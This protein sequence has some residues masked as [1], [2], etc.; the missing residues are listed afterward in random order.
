M[1]KYFSSKQISIKASKKK[2]ETPV[3]KFN[4]C[5]F[6]SSN[7]ELGSGVFFSSLS[8]GIKDCNEGTLYIAPDD[9]MRSKKH[10]RL[11]NAHNARTAILEY[12]GIIIDYRP[13]MHNQ[14]DF[15]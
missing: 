12:Y 7:P 6:E 2:V 1:W 8:P 13:K 4:W 10:M 9:Y 3:T 11:N 5:L 14:S 15:L